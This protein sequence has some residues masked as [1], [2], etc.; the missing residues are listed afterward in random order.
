MKSDYSTFDIQ[1]ALK[2]PRERFRQWIADGYVVPSVPAQGAGTRAS[3]SLMD[4][5]KVALLDYLISR[6]MKRS[7][8]AL[9]TKGL[10]ETDAACNYIAVRNEWGNPPRVSISAL[11]SPIWFLDL[12]QGAV[13]KETDPGN[14]RYSS[15]KP[16]NEWAD[17]YIVNFKVIR[18]K[19]DRHIKG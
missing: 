13:F 3:F 1:K 5:Y 2:I 19:V 10:K 16:S 6:G 7:T 11:S 18:E 12:E 15:F 14:P 4:V 17:I 9:I 8:A